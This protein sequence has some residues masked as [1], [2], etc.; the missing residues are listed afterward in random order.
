MDIE[1][2]NN[3]FEIL[4]NFG[5]RI[6]NLFRNREKIK[7]SE[8]VDS[9]E[10]RKSKKGEFDKRTLFSLSK[11]VRDLMNKKILINSNKGIVSIS[12]TFNL[13]DKGRQLIL[14]EEDKKRIEFG[15]SE[16]RLRYLKGEIKQEKETLKNLKKGL[17]ND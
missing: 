13:T 6:L 8:I 10:I 16:R 5:E 11:N 7:F 14:T 2:E 4:G 9:I 15:K 1:F 17:K 12:E 3:R